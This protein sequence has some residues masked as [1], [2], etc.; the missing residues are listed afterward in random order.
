M[1]C[2]SYRDGKIVIVKEVEMDTLVLQPTAVAQWHALINEAE[3]ACAAQ[4]DEELQSYLVFLLMRYIGASDIANS[5]LALEYLNSFNLEGH[6]RETQLQ[7]VGDKCL[8]YSGLFPGR[9][10]RRRVHISYYVNLGVSAYGAMSASLAGVRARMF[11]DLSAHFVNLMDI[12]HAMR[13]LGSNPPFLQP[14]QAME[15]WQDTGSPHAY[16]TLTRYS[17]AVPVA[18]AMAH[19]TTVRLGPNATNDPKHH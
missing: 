6:L 7:D 9:A 18:G 2:P 15:L 3:Q 14:L 19:A 1:L 17:Q 5:V 11:S 10:E 12:L 13:E 16:Q 4:L 8:L